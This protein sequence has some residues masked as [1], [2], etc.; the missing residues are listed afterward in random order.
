MPHAPAKAPEKPEPRKATL[1]GDDLLSVKRLVLAQGVKNREP[2]D[3][4]TSFKSE[5]GKIYAYVE[6]ENRGHGPGEIVVEFEPPGGGAPH[7]DVTLA[8]GPSA[9]W[10]T[11]AYT[12]TAKTPGA[13]TAV[14]KNRKGDVLARAPFEVTL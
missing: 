5:G 1:S 10:R 13:W 2:I 9:R 11:W 8:V 12:R 3:E 7:G 4:G 14:I 6:V